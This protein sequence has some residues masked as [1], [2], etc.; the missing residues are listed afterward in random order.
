MN[1]QLYFIPMLE[2]A[3]K[4][5]HP[6][7]ALVGVFDKIK[8]LGDR[9]EYAGGY[10]NFKRFMGITS[11][12]YQHRIDNSV[13]Q[14]LL[15]LAYGTPDMSEACRQAVQRL[16]QSKLEWT[17]EF[18]Q[19]CEE[20]PPQDKNDLWPVVQVYRNNQLID[21]LIFNESSCTRSTG[22]ITPGFYHLKFNTG[23]TLWQ[24][25]LTTEHLIWTDAFSERN[26]DV[27][28]ASD[29]APVESTLHTELHHGQ[30]VIRV[31]PGIEWGAIEVTL[32][33]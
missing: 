30:T 15:E 3:L 17:H 19:L 11:T 14:I 4:Q 8:G 21:R 16:V 31:I 5:S 10:T 2:N 13:R 12:V 9:K 33:L 28:A 22:Q 1:K 27:A 23:M 25:N 24:G 18:Q 29:D 26:L 7:E 20:F 32:N 6:G